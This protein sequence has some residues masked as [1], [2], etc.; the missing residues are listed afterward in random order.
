MAKPDIL[1]NLTVPVDVAVERNRSRIKEGKESARVHQHSRPRD[2][3]GTYYTCENI[4][5]KIRIRLPPYCEGEHRLRLKRSRLGDI[6]TG[7][8]LSLKWGARRNFP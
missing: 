7:E 4:S 6:I 8:G 2:G 3:T 1:F 5:F